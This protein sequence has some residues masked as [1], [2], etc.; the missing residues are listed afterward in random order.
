MIRNT[1]RL[2]CAEKD[3]D[4]VRCTNTL[5]HSPAMSKEMVRR[6]V[7]PVG[8]VLV[9]NE[10]GWFWYCPAHKGAAA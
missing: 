7:G 6:L 2:S 8:W 4:G 3:D 5:D 1:G 10:S 9:E